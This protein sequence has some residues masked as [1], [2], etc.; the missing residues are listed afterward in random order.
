MQG[1]ALYGYLEKNVKN[2]HQTIGKIVNED[3]LFRTDLTPTKVENKGDLSMYGISLKLDDVNVV[4]KTIEVYQFEKNERLAIIRDLEESLNQFQGKHQSS[5]SDVMSYLR[6]LE[7]QY[8]ILIL[9]PPAFAKHLNQVSNAMIGYR[10][11]N[12][13]GL[14]HIKSGGLLFT[15]SCS[16]AVDKELFRKIIFHNIILFLIYIYF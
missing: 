5:T 11:L 1:D 16:Q 6:Q 4:S 15:F 2:W 12:T 3:L 13:E 8:D 14:K 10:N 9:D 7:I